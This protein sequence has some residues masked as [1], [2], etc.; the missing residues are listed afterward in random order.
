MTKRL[1]Q[2]QVK[3]Y[4]DPF[5]YT[6][7]HVGS[8]ILLLRSCHPAWRLFYCHFNQLQQVALPLYSSLGVQ[9]VNAINTLLSTF[10][11]TNTLSFCPL[12][13]FSF[14]FRFHFTSFW[15]TSPRRHLNR[16]DYHDSAV[17]DTSPSFLSLPKEKFHSMC[18]CPYVPKLD[19][20][21][22]F[23]HIVQSWQ[24]SATHDLQTVDRKAK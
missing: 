9:Y 8:L 24:P 7:V 12:H 11:I 18:E 16:T 23:K 19:A 21:G 20:L 4:M 1:G 17:G 5:V 6:I 2:V 15:G 10:I 14:S 13:S 3:N 22:R